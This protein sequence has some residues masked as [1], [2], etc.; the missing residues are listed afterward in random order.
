MSCDP[1]D[2]ALHSASLTEAPVKVGTRWTRR[3]QGFR[4]NLSRAPSPS[5]VQQQP[6]R[7]LALQTKAPGPL[8]GWLWASCSGY[9]PPSHTQGH[10]SS[11]PCK[12]CV[13]LAYVCWHH[14]PHWDN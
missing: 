4:R 5:G 11:L 1:E 13:S 2:R 9:D 6:R 12:E 3:E 7:I 14:C 10:V 8:R